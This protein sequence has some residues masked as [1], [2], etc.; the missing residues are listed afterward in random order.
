MLKFGLTA[1]IVIVLISCSHNAYRS[2]NKEYKKQVKEFAK[3]L[4]LKEQQLQRYEAEGFKTVSFQNLMKFINIINL[5]LKVK[6][7]I[8]KPKRKL[9][10]ASGKELSKA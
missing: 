6:E 2:T 5:D 8:I 9:R 7:I 10:T 1:L 3:L 4:G